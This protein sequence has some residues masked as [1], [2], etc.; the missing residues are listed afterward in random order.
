MA[1]N[2]KFTPAQQKAILEATHSFLSSDGTFYI[3]ALELSEILD[4]YIMCH[5][6][7]DESENDENETLTGRYIN[8]VLYLKT[9]I[10]AFFLKLQIAIQNKA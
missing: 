6:E 7:R 10:N 9:N 5:T 3:T 1:T 8:N 4:N 2:H